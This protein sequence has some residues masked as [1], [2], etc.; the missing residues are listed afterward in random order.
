MKIFVI[1]GRPRAGKDQF[2]KFC[3]AHTHWCLN[4]ST[5][6]FVKE[7]AGHCGWDGTKTPENRKFLSDLK[8]LLTKW[9]DVP[10]KKV[11]RE[12][13]LFKGK[14]EIFGFNPAEDGVV[15]IHCR[16]PKEIERLCKDLGAESLLM[17]RAAVEDEEQSNHADAEV[18]NYNYDYT[19]SNEGT[20]E[21]LEDAAVR[22][23]REMGVKISE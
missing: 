20:L 15:F 14:M 2:V 18:F 12:I 5:V 4:I 23:L 10:Y 17:L 8:D 19:I 22:F 13:Q 7:V 21:D 16:E 1:N 9:G 11:C 6:D 3:K